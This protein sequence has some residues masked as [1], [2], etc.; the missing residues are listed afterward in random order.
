MKNCV[1]VDYSLYADMRSS[2]NVYKESRKMLNADGIFGD[3]FGILKG[4]ILCL[5]HYS[6]QNHPSMSQ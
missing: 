6:I 1:V 4:Y 2:R 3:T 5:K